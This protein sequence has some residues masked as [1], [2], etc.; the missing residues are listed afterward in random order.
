MPKLASTAPVEDDALEL[1]P[2]RRKLALETLHEDAEVR[3]RCGGV[4]L[5]DEQ[6]SHRGII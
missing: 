2:A 6:D 1:V 5:G 3:S 4:H